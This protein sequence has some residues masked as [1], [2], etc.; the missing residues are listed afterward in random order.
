MSS[1]DSYGT[2]RGNANEELRSEL[3]KMDLE[4]ISI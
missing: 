2:F 3:E 1:V 4:F